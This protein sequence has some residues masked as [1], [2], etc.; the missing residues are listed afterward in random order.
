MEWFEHI[1][2]W[3]DD[4]DKEPMVYRSFEGSFEDDIL[5]V[6]E[7]RGL[8]R[9]PKVLGYLPEQNRAIG[10]I[11]EVVDK[12]KGVIAWDNTEEKAVENLRKTLWA[13]A[14]HRD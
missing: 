11:I 3:K 6:I 13:C 8:E 1:S 4:D 14:M 5:G 12:K 9:E 10:R 2:D 7:Y